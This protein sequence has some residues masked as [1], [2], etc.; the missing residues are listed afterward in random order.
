MPYS[1]HGYFDPLHIVWRK[2]TPDDPYIDR[3]EYLKV[4]NNKVVLSEI[5]DRFHRVKIAGLREINY[6][7]VPKKNIAP[8]EFSVNYS[9]GVIEFHPS[10]ES[11]TLNIMYKGKGFIQYPS[12]RIYHQDELNDVVES[13]DKIINRAIESLKDVDNKISD[14][15]QLRDEV[16]DAIIESEIATTDAKRATEEAQVA[17]DKALD[18]Y[19]TTRLVFKPYVNTY[20]DIVRTYPN[21]EVG[22]TTQ[23]YDSGVRYRWDGINWVPIDLFGGNI[24]LANH[25]TNGLM[26]KDDKIKLDS[27][28]DRLKERVLTFIIPSYPDVGVQHI[29]ARFPFKGQILNI[30][31]ICGVPDANVDTE[32]AI[33]KSR[34]MVNWT[35]ILTRNIVFR[36]G[37]YFDD[38]LKQISVFDVNKDDIFR[39]EILQIGNDLQDVTIEVIIKIVQ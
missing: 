18:A 39:L 7:G 26:S 36:R 33:Q 5:P 1:N 24:V 28:D 9:T 27:F 30:R 6:D 4:L 11:N 14:Y 19:K 38:G 25:Y 23:V 17:T 32:I 12:S 13:L 22:W 37:E 8:D 15:E 34:D 35:N 3:V 31:G 29:N 16:Q 2:G 10:Q 20:S 21:P